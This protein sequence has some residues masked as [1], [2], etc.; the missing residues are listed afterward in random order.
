MK[1][2]TL[3]AVL[4]LSGGATCA[5]AQSDCNANSSI[6]H[7]AVKAG[8]FKDAYAPCMAV[9]KDCPT[10]RFY[11][12]TD[13]KEILESFL[14]GIKDRNSADYQKY[15]NELMGVFDQE[16]KYIPDFL[17]KGTKLNYGVEGAKGRKAVSYLQYAPKPDVKQAYEWLKASVDA[18]KQES[19]GTIL[20]YFL[21]CSMRLVKADPSHTEQFFTDYLNSTKYA[22]EAIA[23]ETKESRKKSM[24]Q[25]RENLVALFINSGVADCES[26][27]NIYGPQVEANQN[28][29]T[30]LKKAINVLKM[31]KCTESDAYFQASYYMYKINPTADAAVGCGYQAYKKGNYDEAVKYFDEAIGIET[32]N[33]KK[34][35]MAYAA[36]GAMFGAKKYSQVKSYCYKALEFNPEFANAYILLAQAYG[37]SPRWSDEGA[38]NR[39]TY[40]VVLDKLQRAKSIDPSLA[41]QANE[42]IRTYSAHLPESQDLFMLGYKKGDRITVGG[43]IGESTTIR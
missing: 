5:F 3:V 8:N 28:D 13:A 20:F 2:K 12:Y 11:T 34:A 16:M 31:M 42:L 18:E 21:D 27:Q 37:S 39:C 6:S 14:K 40:Y 23:A 43:W 7:E 22:D 15:F 1:I 24:T 29:S 10:L 38:L 25:I 9:L 41:E 33:A 4:L 26:L 17:A 19:S 36:A 32:D 35:E 30:F